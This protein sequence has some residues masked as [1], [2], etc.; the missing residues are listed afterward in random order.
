MLFALV[1]LDDGSVVD[2]TFLIF[3]VGISA[4]ICLILCCAAFLQARKARDLNFQHSEK[5]NRLVEQVTGM[6]LT[7]SRVELK[8]AQIQQR[9]D[10]E[11]LDRIQRTHDGEIPKHDG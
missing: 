10:L 3:I 2:P 8:Q 1:R 6:D 9:L 7:I 4:A 5:V 11:Y